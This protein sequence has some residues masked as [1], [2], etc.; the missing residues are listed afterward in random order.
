[1]CF[2]VPYTNSYFAHISPLVWK[3]PLRS[4]SRREKK[5]HYLSD[6]TS[7]TFVTEDNIL[8]LLHVFVFVLIA[9][10]DILFIHDA[11]FFFHVCV[12]VLHKYWSLSWVTWCIFYSDTFSQIIQSFLLYKKKMLS[13]FAIGH[14]GQRRVPQLDLKKK[15]LT[16]MKAMKVVDEI[17][18]YK[19]KICKQCKK[20]TIT[21][22][23][24]W[25]VV[26]ILLWM[27]VTA[28]E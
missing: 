7:V 2:F 24:S 22:H 25:N 17:G 11:V 3:R 20:W 6:S 14:P 18:E 27:A 4:G 23:S 28:D 26:H 16:N 5:E 15:N 21:S 19:N 12:C 9:E 1:V 13:G 8:I 10:Q